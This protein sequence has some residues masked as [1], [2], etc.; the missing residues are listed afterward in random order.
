MPSSVSWKSRGA[1]FS[2]RRYLQ[3]R[4]LLAK[5]EGKPFDNIALETVA[6]FADKCEHLLSPARE[7]EQ[8]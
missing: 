6:A 3:K 5:D 4:E 2:I 7:A 1:A 8:T